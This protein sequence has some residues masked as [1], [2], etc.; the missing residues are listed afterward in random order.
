LQKALDPKE[1]AVP[2]VLFNECVAVVLISVVQVGFVFTGNVGTG[3]I[4]KKK[5][6]EIIDGVSWSKPVACGITGMGYGFI[7]GASVKDIIIF[8][9]DGHTLT[10]M[11]KDTGVKIGAQAELTLGTFGRMGK[12]D[13]S[14]GKGGGYGSTISFAFTKGIFG[15][16]SMEG[17]VVGIR[18]KC[19]HNF[20]GKDFYPE[21]IIDEKSDVAMPTDRVTLLDEVYAKLDLL[22]A[23]ETVAPDVDDIVASKIESAKVEADLAAELLRES[24]PD[25]TFVGTL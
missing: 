13:Y 5:E 24:E 22:C 18:S 17:A 4:L 12:V 1:K 11:I 15:G 25:V 10:A 7:A 14:L 23:G 21:Q 2:R 3:I 8:V 16:I 9:M 20:Y 19:N 6:G